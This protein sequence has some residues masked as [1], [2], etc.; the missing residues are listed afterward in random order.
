MSLLRRP[1]SR[2]SPQPWPFAPL[3]HD[4]V[5]RSVAAVRRVGWLIN[6]LACDETGPDRTGPLRTLFFPTRSLELFDCRLPAAC[7]YHPSL[8]LISRLP[9]RFYASPSVFSFIVGCLQSEAYRRRRRQRRAAREMARKQLPRL[10]GQLLL[11]HLHHRRTTRWSKLGTFP[12]S[13]REWTT[14]SWATPI[15]SC[16][17]FAWGP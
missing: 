10:L 15:S 7:S 4:P 8:S 11:R 3:V 13:K 5:R 9:A 16:R 12:A 14:S 2:Q 17:G 6:W 1:S